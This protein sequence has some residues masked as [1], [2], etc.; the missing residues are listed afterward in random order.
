M[1][2]R[3]KI[4]LKNLMK[5]GDLLGSAL[6]RVLNASALLSQLKIIWEGTTALPIR[7][8]GAQV[9]GPAAMQC[10]LLGTMV[11]IFLDQWRCGLLL[12]TTAPGRAVDHL[13]LLA[14]CYVAPDL[15]SD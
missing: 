9:S 4:S 2:S 11:P 5:C 6:T 12:G 14:D 7:R 13:S 8:H 15:V 10:S 1:Q 3:A